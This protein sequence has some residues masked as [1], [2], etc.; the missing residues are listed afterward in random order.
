MGIMTAIAVSNL[1]G[2]V[3]K[4]TTVANLASAIGESGGHVLAV[5]LDGSAFALTRAF[6]VV[7]SQAPATTFEVLAGQRRLEDAV[8]AG[9]A[10]GVD[11]LAA[12]RELASLEL[13][14]VSEMGR[15]TVLSRALS[16]HLTGYDA[17]LLDCPPMLSLLTVNALF[18]ASR[19]LVPVSLT[20]PGAVQG[21]IEL[22]GAIERARN[23]GASCEIFSIAKVKVDERRLASRAIDAALAE[24]GLPV[25]E[26][27]VPLTA[28]FDT[29]VARGRPLVIAEPDN[30]GSWAYRR[31]ADEL[32][33]TSGLRAVA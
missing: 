23:A 18:A 7:P 14:L 3:G 19:V 27:T 22:R 31:L 6:G 25:A 4:T 17:V 13:Q 12:R 24:L 10:R 1:K 9:V 28:A 15:E 20:D 8:I 16:G 26:T 5:D 33:L 21:L 30:R 29:A 32:R 11:L 2:G